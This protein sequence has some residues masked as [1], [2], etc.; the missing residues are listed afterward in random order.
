MSLRGG[1][2]PDAA[3]FKLAVWHPGAKKEHMH[4]KTQNEHN[5][6]KKDY[7]TFEKQHASAGASPWSVAGEL[8]GSVEVKPAASVVPASRDDT[9]KIAASLR[10]SQ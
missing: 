7:C 10:S 3:I 9:L 5:A 2:K 8:V 6:F 1:R 4:S